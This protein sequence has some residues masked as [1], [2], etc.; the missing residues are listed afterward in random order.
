MRVHLR[1]M[2][3]LDD[4]CDLTRRPPVEPERLGQADGDEFGSGSQSVPT[5]RSSALEENDLTAT[6]TFDVFSSLDGYGRPAAT[7]AATGAS[8]AP[9]CSTTALPCTARSS[10]W[11]LGQTRIGHSRGCWP[12]ALR[13]P[14][15]VTHGSLG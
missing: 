6:Y 14:K 2:H 1:D 7:G 12:R 15:C 5:H 8:K 13:S 3:T 4:L 9:S 11:S 10:G